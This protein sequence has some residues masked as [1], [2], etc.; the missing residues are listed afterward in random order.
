MLESFCWGITLLGW[1]QVTMFEEPFWGAGGVMASS[2]GWLFLLLLNRKVTWVYL[3]PTWAWQIANIWM[4]LMVLE[5][6]IQIWQLKM[7]DGVLQLPYFLEHHTHT[8]M[9]LQPSAQSIPDPQPTTMPWWIQVTL[10]TEAVDTITY[11]FALSRPRPVSLL[12]HW[13][14]CWEAPG[15]EFAVAL[16][17]ELTPKSLPTLHKPWE[18]V[19]ALMS[20]HDALLLPG[21]FWAWASQPSNEKSRAAEGASA[22][23]GATKHL[24]TPSSASHS[25]G[26]TQDVFLPCKCPSRAW[27]CHFQNSANISYAPYSCCS[28]HPAPLSRKLLIW[29]LY[30]PGWPGTVSKVITLQE[31]PCKKA[32]ARTSLFVK[33]L[34]Q[35]AKLKHLS[36]SC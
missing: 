16:L 31:K 22:S 13:E 29:F 28:H 10:D 26:K 18:A 20:S 2:S 1:G 23:F 14:I 9:S 4:R 3:L 5:V 35:F 12:Y 34:L 19:W 24:L 36:T 8:S 17:G 27:V 25:P 33:Q 7:V 15:Q 6:S 30:F 11:H 21:G 32:R